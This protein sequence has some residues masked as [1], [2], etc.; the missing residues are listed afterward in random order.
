MKSNYFLFLSVILKRMSRDKIIVVLGLTASGK[1]DLAVRLAKKI[2]DLKQSSGLFGQNSRGEFLG[3]VVSADS[4]QV[5]KGLDIGT[6]KVPNDKILNFEFRIL[7]Q[8]R[9]KECLKINTLEIDSKLKIR[10]FYFYKGV[11]HHLIDVASPKKVFTVADYRRLGRKAIKDILSR[12]KLPIIC[13]G[14][15]FYI[16]ALIYDSPLPEAPPQKDLREKLEKKTNEELFQELK[17]L[18]LK[19]AQK[20]DG[21]NKR[22][23]VRALEIVMTTGKPVPIIKKKP[24]FDVLKIGIRRDDKELKELI[25]ERLL[26]RI[27][28]GMIEEAE[29]LHKK[30]LSW[31]RIE[32]LGL[33]YR[34][35][36]RYL[37]G[38]ITK[39]EMIQSL[40]NEI[41]HYAKRQMT[42]FKKDG[43]IRWVEDI[44]EAEKTISNWL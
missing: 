16:D 34:Y 5:Y 23:L 13:G 30:G 28:E 32:E 38:L 25:E 42:W 21:K 26:K 15:G 40:K 7:N 14:T 27:D 37:R 12:G 43:E 1:S 31:K 36:S 17:K 29:N 9:K 6:G 4:R 41:R 10:N 11:R 20:I 24:L 33:E 22:R 8:K 2:G 18:D 19:T 35:L 3:E 44:N 39:D